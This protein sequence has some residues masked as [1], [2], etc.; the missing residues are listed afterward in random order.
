MR[1]FKDY[2]RQEIANRQSEIGRVQTRIDSARSGLR[3]E[4]DALYRRYGVVKDRP[5]Q[6]LPADGMMEE[7]RINSRLTELTKEST[8][9]TEELGDLKF[10]LH[11]RNDPAL[12]AKLGPGRD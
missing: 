5:G 7:I 8:A 10:E 1:P 11:V 12:T 2:T 3:A 6:Y 4:E 9:L